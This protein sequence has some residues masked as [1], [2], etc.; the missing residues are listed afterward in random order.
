MPHLNHVAVHESS[1]CPLFLPLSVPW[2]GVR[3]REDVIGEV[4]GQLVGVA[5]E[6]VQ[7]HV[8]TMSRATVIAALNA[9]SGK[10]ILHGCQCQSGV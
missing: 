1:S 8:T 5:F 2:E 7:S 6:F 4:G 3:S 9:S 10:K